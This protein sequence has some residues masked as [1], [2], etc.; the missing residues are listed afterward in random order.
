MTC[1]GL[2]NSPAPAPEVAAPLEDENLL[3]EILVRLAPLPSALPRASLVCKRWR[4]LVTDRR[5][6]RRFRAHHLR[7]AP[8]LI[9]FFEE[10]SRKPDAPSPATDAP[11]V[12]SFTPALEPPDRVPVG[13]FSLRLHDGSGR[14]NIGC[15]D[16]LVLLIDPANG[17]IQSGCVFPAPWLGI[18]S[19]GPFAQFDLDTQHLAVIHLPCLGKCRRNGSRTFRAVPVDGGELGVLELLDANL[20]LWKRKVDRDGVV[21]WVLGKTIGLEE[22]LYID[23]RKMGPMMLGYCEDNN[24]VFIW[25]YHGIF[26]VQLESLEVYKPPIHTFYCL[27]HPFTSVYTAGSGPWQ[28]R[29]RGDCHAQDKG[30]HPEPRQ[31]SSVPHGTTRYE[32]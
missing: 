8:P 9:G 31:L 2:P 6:V 17:A 16:G 26:M 5:F 22:L 24:V 3:P 29:A 21:S 14:S 10:V 30:F 4:R 18:P 19:T 28:L 11:E 13:R 27:V 25:T 7:S 1:G 23:K 15:R 20:H 12:L 32:A